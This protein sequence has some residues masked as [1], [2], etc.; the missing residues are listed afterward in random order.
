MFRH[1]FAVARRL[2]SDVPVT[3]WAVS[4]CLWYIVAL[5]VATAHQEERFLLP[6]LPLL[7]LVVAWVVQQWLTT[8]TQ[9]VQ[10]MD[11]SNLDSIPHQVLARSDHR[12]AI[13]G[14][15]GLD[16]C[17][18]AASTRTSRWKVALLSTI[19]AAQIL[20]AMYL[21]VFHQVYR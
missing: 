17:P 5:R 18:S 16:R 8:N 19:S 6:I 14:P 3:R 21:L 9:F 13:D 11:R 2:N 10:Q 15:V 1:I 12:K 7:H 4:L 20:G